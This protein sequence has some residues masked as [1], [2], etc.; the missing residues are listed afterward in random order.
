MQR[1]LKSTSSMI[2]SEMEGWVVNLRV[3]ARLPVLN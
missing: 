1:D 2:V 3:K